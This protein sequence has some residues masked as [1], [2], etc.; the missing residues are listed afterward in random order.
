MT[1]LPSEC[2]GEHCPDDRWEKTGHTTSLDLTAGC[3]S[4]VGRAVAGVPRSV[5]GSESPARDR[6]QTPNGAPMS[7]DHGVL[8]ELG[9]IE[10]LTPACKAG[11]LPI[12]P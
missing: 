8:V 12:A 9:R 7:A 1:A 3:C 5:S 6:A 11:A 4:P 2:L 10:P